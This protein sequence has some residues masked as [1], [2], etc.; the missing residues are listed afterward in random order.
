M[1]ACSTV[2]PDLF[3]VDGKVRVLSA[4]VNGLLDFGDD[5]GW[6]GYVGGG[7]GVA[8]V[9]YTLDQEDFGS[10]SE[11]DGTFAW[12][13]IAGVRKAVSANVDLGL[14]YRF[15]NT[16]K[17]K[18]G[19]DDGASAGQVPLALAA[20]EPDLQ[21]RSAAASAAASAASAASAAASAGDADLPGRFGDPGDGKLS[22][23]SAA[24]AAAAASAGAGTR[25][26]ASGSGP[27]P[28]R[29]D[30]AAGLSAKVTPGELRPS[31]GFFLRVAQLTGRA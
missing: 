12:Q 24:A 13:V 23:A 26:R 25:L 31:R 17:Y 14:K 4:M 16:T 27:S 9:K 11:S 8:R 19:D 2:R 20:A 21:L 15:F 18:F 10:V 1:A 6:N 28:R 7:V 30:P 29:S 5:D 3:D 22:A